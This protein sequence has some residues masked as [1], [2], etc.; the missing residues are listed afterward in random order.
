MNLYGP[1][2]TGSAAFLVYLKMAGRKKQGLHFYEKKKRFRFHIIKEAGIW[3]L[4]GGVAAFLAAVLVFAFGKKITTAGASMEP[5]LVSG[6]ICLINNISYRI[7]SVEQYDVIA[8]YPGGNTDTY[9][10]IKRVVAVPGD[11]VLIENGMLLINGIPDISS[12]S[13]TNIKNA[14][15]ANTEILLG[16]DEYFVLGDNTDSSEDSR[17]ASIGVVREEA[18]IGKVWYRLPADGSSMGFVH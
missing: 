9:P 8:F 5:Q 12:D 15:I 4:Y 1:H 13:Y 2:F 6:Q 11:S 16:E 3:L 14:G 18:I 7:H 10:Y 17:S